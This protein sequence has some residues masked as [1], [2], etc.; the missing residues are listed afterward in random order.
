MNYA[1]ALGFIA[2]ILTTAAYVP[3]VHKAWH[4]KSTKDLSGEYL[5]ITAVGLF[6]WIV[7]GMVISSYPLM[8]ANVVSISLVLSLIYIKATHGWHAK[9]SRP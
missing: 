9:A 2:G 6:I 4:T 8:A 7:Y 5:I 3:Q 1:I